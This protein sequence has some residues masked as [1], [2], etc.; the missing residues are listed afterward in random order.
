[1]S[2]P[3]MPGPDA[4]KFDDEKEQT[5]NDMGCAGASSKVLEPG[6]RL[7]CYLKYTIR[8]RSTRS[9][10]PV[11]CRLPRPDIRF[12]IWRGLLSGRMHI[13]KAPIGSGRQTAG[14]GQPSS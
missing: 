7:G 4:F 6:N 11:H 1:M 2:F 9:A 8:P 12:V 3:V 14:K 13:Q 10:N 5:W